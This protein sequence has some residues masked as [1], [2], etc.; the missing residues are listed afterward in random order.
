M[1]IITQKRIWEAKRKWPQTA[2]ALDAWYRL[3]KASEP[4]GFAEM[5]ALFPATDK[6]GRQHVF[7]IG[8]N[9]I[10][11]IAVVHYRY[12]KIYIQHVLDHAEY[13]KGTWKEST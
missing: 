11:L 13:D 5:K 9:K 2:S 12:K 4:A 10:R 8:G 6:V 1:H 3:M 7:D